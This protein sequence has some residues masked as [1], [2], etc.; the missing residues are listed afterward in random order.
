[1]FTSCLR[2]CLLVLLMVMTKDCWAQSSSDLVVESDSL[3]DKARKRGIPVMLY[4]DQS[5]K[6]RQPVMIISHGYN[7]NQGSP[8]MGYSFIAYHYA[9][10]GYFVISIQHE[11]ATDPLIPREGEIKVVRMPFWQ[12]GADNILFVR[13]YYLKKYKNLDPQNI[14][15]VGHS[16][17]GDMSVL[18]AK[19]HP[20][21]VQNLITLDHRRMDVP[22]SATPRLLSLRSSEFT[23]DEGVFPSPADIQQY[24]MDIVQMQNTQHADFSDAGPAFTKGQILAQMDRFLQEKK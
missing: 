15:L 16:N 3:Y 12:R 1:M 20:N 7:A 2:A 17:G 23:A 8:Y 10:K 24:K 6:E 14:T 5:F 13:D 9:V 4:H 21:F 22:R 18:F 11:L 19:E